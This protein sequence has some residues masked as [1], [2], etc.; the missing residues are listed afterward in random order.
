MSM[1]YAYSQ[2]FTV[3]IYE[4]YKAVSRQTGAKI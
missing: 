1:S 2:T 4:T 3:K